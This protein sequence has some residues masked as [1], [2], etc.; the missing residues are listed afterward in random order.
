MRISTKRILSILAGLAFLAGT[1][2][3]YAGLIRGEAAVVG[4]TR[5]LLASKDALFADQEQAVS[6]VKNLIA[7]FKN[8]SRLEETVGR[9]I[10]NGVS[11]IQALRQIEAV[12]RAAGAIITSLDFATPSVAATKK[13]TGSVIKRLRVLEVKAKAEGSYENLKQFVKL[14]ETSVRVANV[15][16]FHYVPGGTGGSGD[17]VELEVEMYYQE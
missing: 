16:A 8:S 12:A 13:E 17:A 15:K 4:D 3:V 1:L 9:A 14:I 7:E 2:G 6:Q 11:A 10:P 5:A